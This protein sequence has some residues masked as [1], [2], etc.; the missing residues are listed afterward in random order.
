M[1]TFTLEMQTLSIMELVI[2]GTDGIKKIKRTFDGWK[3]SL[4]I[5]RSLL[6]GVSNYLRRQ[7]R[8]VTVAASHEVGVAARIEAHRS[9]CQT[10]SE[11]CSES[12][13]EFPPSELP[14]PSSFEAS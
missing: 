11:L 9:T 10:S 8:A 4:K 1:R 5:P 2:G 6:L 14:S 3:A 7:E 12:S 13:S